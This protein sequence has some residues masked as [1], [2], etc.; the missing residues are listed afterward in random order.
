MQPNDT[1]VTLAEKAAFFFWHLSEVL[2]KIIEQTKD[3]MLPISH[4]IQYFFSNDLTI[5]ELYTVSADR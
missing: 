3:N 1:V 5:I 4:C 2:E